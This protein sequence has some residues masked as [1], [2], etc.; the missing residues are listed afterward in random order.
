MTDDLDCCTQCTC[1]SCSC[2]RNPHVALVALAG[3]TLGLALGYAAFRYG[4]SARE[5]LAPALKDHAL[6][7]AHE[8][9][10]RAR[11]AL[12]HR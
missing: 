1:P 8:A 7:L 12:P 2:D 4:P 5:R 6:P 9:Y 11:A 10:A 3:V